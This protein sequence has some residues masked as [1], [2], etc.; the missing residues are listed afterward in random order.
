M[1]CSTATPAF[2]ASFAPVSRPSL[3][4]V[5]ASSF[6][7]RAAATAATSPPRRP[8]GRNPAPS[9]SPTRYS[10]ACTAA[11]AASNP[12]T[13][14]A[15]AAAATAASEL[16]SLASLRKRRVPQ[17]AQDDDLVDA[18]HDT[19]VVAAADAGHRLDRLLPSHYQAQ[20]RSYF[21][22]LID[23]RLV[24]VND[25]VCTAKARKAV[26]GDTIHVCFV[27]PT[28]D[29]PLTPEDIALDILYEDEHMVVVNKPAGLVVHP[30]PGNWTGTLVHAL[31]F[32]YRDLL[33]LGGP[34]PGIVH[35]LD[36][37]TS[38]VMLAARTADAHRA[39]TAMFAAREVEKT[40]VA[41]TVGNPAGD[42]CTSRIV[43]APIGRSRA[44][45]LR[46]AVMEEDAGGK[47]ARSVVRVVGCDTRSLLHVVELGL[48]T[49]RTHQLRVHLRHVRAPVLGDDLYGAFDVNRRF[50]SAASRPLLHAHRLRFAHPLTGRE[51][52]IKAPLP[53]DMRTLLRTG[54][55]PDFE[56][57]RPDW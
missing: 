15:G 37:G 57:A 38:G 35:R 39:L 46:M 19:F 29:L 7:C 10:A 20:S 22:A 40:Y 23:D 12:A 6:V 25:V 41:I 47:H 26:A 48:E 30:A 11:H 43:D 5:I 14:V 21:Q 18:E 44:D 42:G 17:V 3:H 4:S 9:A 8:H 33:G 28:R 31:A 55:L 45:R 50:R 32:R 52:D 16:A 2:A 56:T 36:K 1:T 34:R 49:G 54:L 24:R 53:D 51:V 27:T 13:T